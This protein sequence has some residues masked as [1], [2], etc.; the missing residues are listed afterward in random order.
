M[1]SLLISRLVLWAA[2]VAIG[3]A[4]L[5]SAGAPPVA[6]ATGHRRVQ[7]GPDVAA[8]DAYVE[9]ELRADRVP[10]AALAVVQGVRIVQLRGFGDDGAGRPVTPQTAFLLGSMSKSF[11]A[12]AV[13]QLVE[14][15]RIDLDAPAQRYLPWFRVADARASARITVRHLLHHTSGIPQRAPHASGGQLS[16]DAHVR[17][18]AGVGLRHEPGAAHEYSSPNYLVLGAILQQVTGEPY[19]DYVQRHILAP[20]DMRYSFTSQAEAL[21]GTMARG[22][23]YW[24]G[25]PLPVVLDYEADRMPTAA[26]ISSAQ[27]LAHYLIAHLNEGRYGDQTVL[28][29]AGVAQLHRPGAAGEGYAYAMGWRV[30][31]IGGRPAVHHGGVVPHFRGKMVLLP[32]ERWGVA[33]LTNVS[34][35]LPLPISPTSHRMADAIAASLVGEPLPAPGSALIQ[36]YLALSVGIALLTLNQVKDLAGLRRWGARLASQSRRSVALGLGAE[37][38]TPV[39]VL[40]GLPYLLRLPFSEVLRSMPDVGYWLIASSLIGLVVGLCKLVIAWRQWRS[41][42]GIPLSESSRGQRW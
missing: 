30:G 33:V 22:H 16:I 29:P 9:A 27:D 42:A 21:R 14:Q 18:L 20:L 1:A 35:A 32:G 6:R 15:G 25:F 28:S 10:G 23:R 11:T 31:E 38:L 5:L 39:A 40:L 19:A 34:S 2:A 41:A 17:A 24:F 12:L 4:A 37:L 26:L 8:L 7:A 36:A 3:A 13:M